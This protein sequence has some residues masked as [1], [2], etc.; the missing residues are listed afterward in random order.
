MKKN[1]S[2]SIIIE[3]TNEISEMSI[4]GEVREKV[5]DSRLKQKNLKKKQRNET[6]LFLN[7]LEYLRKEEDKYLREK[8]IRALALLFLFAVKPSLSFTG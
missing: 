7:Q 5:I 8:K 1:G 6:K 4:A 3:I 2:Q